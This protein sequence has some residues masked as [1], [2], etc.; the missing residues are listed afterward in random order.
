MPALSINK[1][2]PGYYT[3]FFGPNG[4]TTMSVNQTAQQFNATRTTVNTP[5]FRQPR[6]KWT[7]PMNPFTFTQEKR[8]WGN[9]RHDSWYVSSGREYHTIYTGDVYGVVT[10]PDLTIQSFTAADKAAL[11]AQCR[12]K[13]RNKIKDQKANWV[14]FHAE[15]KQL[16]NMVATTCDR[17]T[18]AVSA[19]KR[20]HYHA[21][22][23]ALGVTAS[24]RKERKYKR[25][26]AK[27]Q[28]KAVSNGWLELQ[29][30]W[31]PLIGDVH[32]TAELLAQKIE[33]E[34][35]S[36]SVAVVKETRQVKSSAVDYAGRKTDIT[37]TLEHT[38]RYGVY[39]STAS[40]AAHTLSQIGISNPLLIA[41][42]LLPWSFVVDWFIPI[43]NW[44]SSFDATVGLSFEKGYVTVMEKCQLSQVY[45]GTATKT[46]PS[47]DPKTFW[48]LSSVDYVK[49][50]R[51][52]LTSFP[53][54]GMPSF[55]NPVSFTHCANALAL[56][57]QTFKK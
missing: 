43:G 51:A 32:G 55:K 36:K 12:N 42:E 53:S 25:S 17:F 27:D 1:R 5:K 48:I 56:L 29:Y 46:S 26:Y 39:Y 23:R 52:I 28:S 57:R 41:W 44:I 8:L 54:T 47:A 15:R 20:G 13:L 16:I 3:T 34:I 6:P 37:G 2:I 49:C 35:K 33:K 40:E 21:A 38:V 10:N 4:P 18:K 50:N 31:L 45:S 24:H 30:G 14:Q 11:D 9:G 7:L 19:L 22:A